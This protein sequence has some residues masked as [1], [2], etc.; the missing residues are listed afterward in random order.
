MSYEYKSKIIGFI[1]KEQ[2]EKWGHPEF[3]GRPIYQFAKIHKHANKH[4]KQFK[5]GEKSKNYTMQHISD[6]ISNPEYI[7]YNQKNDG[8]EYHK[9]L[10]EYVVVT[11]KPA[12]D[13]PDVFCVSTVYPS[14]EEKMQNRMSKE[15]DVIQQIL[16]D[17]YTYKGDK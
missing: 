12:N 4:F 8:F 2:A 15:Q 13:N 6:V 9:E 3:T 1:T 17:K 14:S 10:M 5:K 11:I 7:C 16:L